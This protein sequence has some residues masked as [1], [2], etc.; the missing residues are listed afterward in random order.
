MVKTSL[1]VFDALSYWPAKM[2]HIG[3]FL[4]VLLRECKKWAFCGADILKCSQQDFKPWGVGKIFGNIQFL[5]ILL[6]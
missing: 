3:Q 2:T 6:L 5:E 1:S 4:P